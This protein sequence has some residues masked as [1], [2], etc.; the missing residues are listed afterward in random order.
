[1]ENDYFENMEKE[2]RAKWRFQDEMEKVSNKKL[3]VMLG[4][5]RGSVSVDGIL[6]WEKRCCGIIRFAFEEKYLGLERTKLS[7]VLKTTRLP[8]GVIVTL[9][10]K[11]VTVEESDGYTS[12]CEA[13]NEEI[14]HKIS[15]YFENVPLM[16]NNE[17]VKKELKKRFEES[18][19]FHQ[20][21]AIKPIFEQAIEHLDYSTQGEVKLNSQEE[22]ALFLCLLGEIGGGKICR[23]TTMD[24]LFKM[25]EK[26]SQNMCSIA[27][28]NDPNEGSYADSKMSWIADVG[29]GV[30]VINQENGVYLLSCSKSENLDTL[31]MWR[32]YGDDAKGVC[33]EYD[34]L[35]EKIDNE[36][37][38]LAPVNYGIQDGSHPELEFINHIQ[39][40]PLKK[41][42]YFKFSNW[43]RWKYF[44]KSY[45]YAVEKE[46]RLVYFH[47]RD[48]N[49]VWYRDS[50]NGI[51]NQ[52]V[53][54]PI[55][56]NDCQF[57]LNLS[58][59]ILGPKTSFPKKNQEQIGEMLDD[60]SIICLDIDVSKIDNYR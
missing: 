23:Y 56:M 27:S 15:V 51:F 5:N 42:W 48:K 11:F 30:A 14:A 53:C 29:R 45:D 59:I 26:K 25:I 46:I 7:D 33:L 37:F 16:L 20:K 19:L 43:F 2:S 10:K 47:V 12:F 44:F 38:F 18:P 17:S 9:D 39:S 8:I 31:T 1:M 35:N 50:A 3:E 40:E 57:P 34:V 28:M 32:L 21:E 60:S 54:F 24:N 22:D 6:K 41:G 58:R 13:D 52:M 4:G 36:K 49:R 55:N